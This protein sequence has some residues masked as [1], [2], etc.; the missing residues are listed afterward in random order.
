MS[1]PSKAIGIATAILLFIIALALQQIYDVIILYTTIPDFFYQVL[2]LLIPCISLVAFG[3]FVRL[4]KSTLK[5]QGYKKP[6]GI[7]TS[8]CILLSLLFITIYICI[9]LAQGFFGSLGELN[10]PTGPISLLFRVTIAVTYGLFSES[11]FRGY[12][13]KNFARNYGLFTSLYASSILFSLHT[14]SIREIPSITANPIIYIFTRIIPPLAT[15]LFLGFFFY[16]IRWSLIGP[17]AFRIG[18]LLF[19]EPSALISA[20][21]PWWIALTFEIL[22]FAVLILLVDSIIREPEYRRKRYG[23]QE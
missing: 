19:F 23:L 11:V 22:A 12:I 8:K 16:K 18:F 15:G 2:Y 1:Y 3:L 4:T 9:V 20:D 14:I 7:S 13:F 5:N 6:A 17:L 10:L 21:S